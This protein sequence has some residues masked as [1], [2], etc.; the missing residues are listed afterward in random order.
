LKTLQAP[1]IDYDTNK[2]NSNLE[3]IAKYEELLNKPAEQSSIQTELNEKKIALSCE[4]EN[5]SSD[6]AKKE[7]IENSHKRIRQ[8]EE[9]ERTMN[10]EMADLERREFLLKS[11]EFA[12]NERYESEINKMFHFVK[13]MLF[14]KQ[15]DG[16]IVPGCECMADGVPYSTQNKA[17][18]VAI[19][20]D[21]I[22]AICMKEGIYAPIFID[23]RESVTEIPE[24][25]A[26]IIN[27]VVNPN[28]PAL[29][30]I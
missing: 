17:M 30:K 8:L 10:Q 5:L 12:K 15:V 16:Q 14:K 26:Q 3:E 4:I 1:H 2:Y 13:F 27:L 11:F 18:Q 23:N 21:I 25:K 28:E 6:Y 22:D 29:R 7:I 24:I 20:L 9:Q 19:G